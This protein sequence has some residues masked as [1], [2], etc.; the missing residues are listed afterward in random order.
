MKT[1]AP[2]KLLQ[3]FVGFFGISEDLMTALQ[4]VSCNSLW[5]SSS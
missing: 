4:H 1:N 3:F 5:V 2:G